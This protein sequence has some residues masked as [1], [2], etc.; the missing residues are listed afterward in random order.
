MHLHGIYIRQFDWFSFTESYFRQIFQLQFRQLQ[1]LGK[2]KF[3]EKGKITSRERNYQR[4]VINFWKIL[5]SVLQC[6]YNLFP[7]IVYKK[8]KPTFAILFRAC[9]YINQFD[10]FSLR[11][12]GISD[13]FLER[14]VNQRKFR[15]KRKN[16]SYQPEFRLRPRQMKQRNELSNKLTFCLTVSRNNP[17]NPA[18]MSPDSF[19]SPT[20]L[21]VSHRSTIFRLHSIWC[22]C[23]IL[24]LVQIKIDWFNHVIGTLKQFLEYT[25]YILN[26]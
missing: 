13:K 14:D 22:F 10:W 20:S 7:P 24:I 17:I 1:L 2:R 12:R 11:E 19:I 9:I 21:S 16:Y 5:V 15:K 6:S 18:S 4:N 26:N 3:W 23:H 25:K 8:V